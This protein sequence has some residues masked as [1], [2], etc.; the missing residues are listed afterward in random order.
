M[1]GYKEAK[2]SAYGW[3][4]RSARSPSWDAEARETWQEG[5]NDAEAVGFELNWAHCDWKIDVLGVPASIRAAV[6]RGTTPT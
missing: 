1:R 4:T 5:Q 2:S 3:K 6:E